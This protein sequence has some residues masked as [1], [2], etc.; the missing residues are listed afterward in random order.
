MYQRVKNEKSNVL[1]EKICCDPRWP[2]CFL[3]ITHSWVIHDFFVFR[4]QN[5]NIIDDY[6]ATNI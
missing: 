3:D 4:H 1:I 6:F 2:V 5:Y